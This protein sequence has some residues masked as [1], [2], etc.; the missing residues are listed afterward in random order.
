M[1]QVPIV[2]DMVSDGK[3][4]LTEAVVTIPRQG[5]PVLQVKIIRRRI[6]LG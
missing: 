4:S 3:S 1:W 2:E 6:E 5:H